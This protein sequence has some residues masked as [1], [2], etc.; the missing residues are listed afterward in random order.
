[1]G[2]RLRR[3]RRGRSRPAPTR[4]ESWRVGWPHEMCLYLYEMSLYLYE[5]SLYLYEMSR[6]LYEMSRYLCGDVAG[7]ARSRSK[8]GSPLSGA[9]VGSILSHAGETK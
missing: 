4:D 8:R 6:Y 5:M 2:Q 7:C 3:I 1:M 9:H